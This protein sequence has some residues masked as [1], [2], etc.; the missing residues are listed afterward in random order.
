[1][2]TAVKWTKLEDLVQLAVDT[3][4]ILS[5]GFVR[6]KRRW[7]ACAIVRV[8]AVKPGSLPYNDGALPITF[9]VVGGV[10]TVSRSALACSAMA[11][12]DI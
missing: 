9:S 3:A 6:V 11:T 12:D 1:M 5:C 7:L 2:L 8:A 10:L 4:A